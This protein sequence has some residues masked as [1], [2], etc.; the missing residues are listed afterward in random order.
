MID[1]RRSHYLRLG[2]PLALYR[3]LR[4]VPDDLPEAPY[5]LV[6]TAAWEQSGAS[7]PMSSA[8]HDGDEALR[9]PR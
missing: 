6:A 5:G 4:R 1:R 8:R 3:E 7:D 2:V 9:L